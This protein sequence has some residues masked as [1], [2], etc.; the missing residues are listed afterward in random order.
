M[1]KY[2]DKNINNID[3]ITEF[4]VREYPNYTTKSFEF[5]SESNMYGK[6][7]RNDEEAVKKYYLSLKQID[8]GIVELYSDRYSRESFEYNL[9]KQEFNISD[10]EILKRVYSDKQL[11][12]IL[13]WCVLHQDELMQNWELSKDGKPLNKINPLI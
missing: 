5:L 13:A 3:Y 11:K 12:L 6:D 7:I 2:I 9:E 8:N 4:T 10:E 1:Q